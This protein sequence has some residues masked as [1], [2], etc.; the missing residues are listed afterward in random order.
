MIDPKELTGLLYAL[1][2]SV[3]AMKAA[4]RSGEAPIA[5]FLDE[6]H[7]SGFRITESEPKGVMVHDYKRGQYDSVGNSIHVGDRVRVKMGDNVSF[8]GRINFFY[9]N[10]ELANVV[11][12]LASSDIIGSQYIVQMQNITKVS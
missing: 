2:R 4:E 1:E 5:A 6:L 10:P 3:A 9:D 11:A 8:L 12:D 7:E